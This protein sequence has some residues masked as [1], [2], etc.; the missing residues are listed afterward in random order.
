MSKVKK[1]FII[2]NLLILGIVGIVL[3]LLNVS[4]HEEKN[5]L[6]YI[7]IIITIGI[8][9]TLLSNKNSKKVFKELIEWIYL[10]ASFGSLFL[11]IN[12]YILYFSRVQGDSMNPTLKNNN[13]V[14]I[15]TFNY[16]PKVNDI[17]IYDTTN[18]EDRYYVKRVAGVKGDTI[19][20][21]LIEGRAYV[22]INDIE[23]KNEYGQSYRVLITDIMYELYLNESYTLVDDEL[24]I[25][26]DNANNSKDS[27]EIG[28]VS[29]NDI[30]GK[31]L[32]K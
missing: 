2:S 11:I 27:R 7:L 5:T 18:N 15:Y 28:I 26:G 4:K 21:K 30:I 6:L 13:I 12:F 23:Y 25:L 9:A 17:V 14:T 16:S 22:F 29:T 3:S 1:I 10:I 32:N 19:S 24:I 31:V 8:T 20:V